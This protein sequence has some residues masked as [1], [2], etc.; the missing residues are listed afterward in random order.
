MAI[1]LGGGGSASQI[2]EV[3]TLNNDTDTVTLADG[4]VYLKGGVFETTT[5]TYPLASSSMQQIGV[6][7]YVGAE[8]IYP[9]GVTWDGTFFWVIGTQG[10]EALKYSSAGVYQSVAWSTATQTVNPYAITW[11]GTSFWV[12]DNVGVVFKYNAS[13]VYQSVSWSTATETGGSVGD[14]E[15]DGT[16]FWVTGTTNQA[17][18]KYNSTGVY[19][20]V[21]WSTAGETTQPTG[22]A[23]DGTSFWVCDRVDERL[24]KYNSSG[25]YQNAFVTLEELNAS[26]ACGVGTNV[27]VTG[28]TS[29]RVRVYGAAIGVS[30]VA[31]RGAQNYVRVA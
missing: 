2:N 29:D 27:A 14:I 6:N 20:S 9:Q 30:S 26:G 21:S 31:D 7:F 13:G 10:D 1:T 24:L 4:R 22:I 8:D 5:S 3:V 18:Y 16:F 23:W 19:Q 28:V 25:V 12:M 11:D 15:W 17:V